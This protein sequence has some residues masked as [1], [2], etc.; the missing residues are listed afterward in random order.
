MAEIAVMSADDMKQKVDEF[1]DRLRQLQAQEDEDGNEW[2]EKLERRH[3]K[4][5]STLE[6]Y[7]NDLIA[8]TRR[9]QSNYQQ[10]R[11]Y[12]TAWVE[13]TNAFNRAFGGQ[14]RSVD[15]GDQEENGKVEEE[16]HVKA[17]EEAHRA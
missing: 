16:P 13:L 11:E 12:M 17:E 3:E 10:L 15:H 8:A 7:S 5:T 6:D 4:L 2:L 1:G 14:I 9:V